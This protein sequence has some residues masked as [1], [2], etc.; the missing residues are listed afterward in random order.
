MDAELKVPTS[1]G[2]MLDY[3]LGAMG[4]QQLDANTILALLSLV[5]LTNILELIVNG[6]AQGSRPSEVAV[7]EQAPAENALSQIIP[8]GGDKSAMLNNLL[9]L[10]GGSGDLSKLMPL[11]S[12]LGGALKNSQQEAPAASVAK[13]EAPPIEAVE[14]APEEKEVRSPSGWARVGR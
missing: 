9:G 10:L 13:E 11:V 3:C 4:Q 2:H 6:R 7:K 14:A 8:P 5:N 1:G 12:M